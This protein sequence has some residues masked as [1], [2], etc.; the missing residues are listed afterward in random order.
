MQE[1]F[2]EEEC[3]D[4]IELSN[5]L[6]VIKYNGG[7]ENL[8]TINYVGWQIPFNKEYKWIFDRMINTFKVENSR[9][10]IV[11][12]PTHIGLHKYNVGDKFAKH[13]DTNKNRMWAIGTN[14]NEEY[15]GGDFYLYEPTYLLPR[16][17]GEIYYFESTRYHEVLEILEGHRWSLILFLCVEHLTFKKKLI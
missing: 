13:N 17:K 16:Q 1:Y 15:N 8:D 4:I 10:S 9:V 6:P 11:K 2:T 14:L 5:Q 3:L 12:Y 7:Y